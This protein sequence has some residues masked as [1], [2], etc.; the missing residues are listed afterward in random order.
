MNDIEHINRLNAIQADI[1]RMALAAFERLLELLKD[2]GKSPREAISE[3]Q[4]GFVGE[5]QSALLQA[6]NQ[7][8][9]TSIGTAELKDLRIGD[10][11]LSDRL[12]QHSRNVQATA[13]AIIN[14]HAKGFHDARKLA[15]QLYE[16][17]QFRQKEPL[18]IRSPLPKYIRAAFG[19]DAAFKALW[20]H[21]YAGSKLAGLADS[22][23]VGPELAQLY[24]R[25][26][27]TQLK[28]PYLKA[29]YLQALDALQAGKGQQ[30]LSK[31]LKIAFYER[32]RYFAN[33]IAQTELH[34]AY[35]DKV[36]GEIMADEGFDYVQI[37]MSQTHPKTDICDLHS[38]LDKY[39]LGPG[40]YPKAQAPKPPY[41][42]FCRC[43]ASPLAWVD[44]DP[45]ENP[46]AERAFLDS[47]PVH[48]ARQVMGSADKLNAVLHG[49][50]VEDVLNAGIDPLYHLRRLGEFSAQS[51]IMAIS[52]R[53][54]TDWRKLNLPSAKELHNLHGVAESSP[55]LGKTAHSVDV[56]LSVLRTGLDMGTG[57][58]KR[59]KTPVEE[60]V[61]DD[62]W[63]PHIV[64]KRD[65]AR[66]RYVDWIMPTLE[67][68]TE[69]WMAAHGEG[70]TRTR[71]IK[72]FSDG[73]YD[74]LVVVNTT[75]D[76]LLWNVIPMPTR[77]LDNQRTGEL[78]WKS[79]QQEKG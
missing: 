62:A 16:G 40:I 63:L 11:K 75:K 71:Y 2:S 54:S 72:L 35:T 38:K 49:K 57:D 79:Y 13:L 77:S 17:Y 52:E 30:V 48:E 65:A 24:A 4:K 34:R 22:I 58:I 73:K 78:L 36:A 55:Q 53:H 64:E 43:V 32:N 61:I 8:L 1:N 26:N 42:C 10:L 33:R 28:T 67:R 56:A 74:M 23:E 59:V 45:R 37:R 41:H 9:V 70:E 14:D 46:T 69:V 39:G 27:A 12:Y 29:A 68:P 15:L 19:D 47:L 76:S 21:D 60:I 51:P 7:I 6:F 50:R 25:I 18:A 66:E 5:Y 31:T 3:V 44:G 20:R